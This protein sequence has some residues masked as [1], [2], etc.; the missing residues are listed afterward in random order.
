MQHAV[1]NAPSTLLVVIGHPTLEW[2]RLIAIFLAGHKLDIQTHVNALSLVVPVFLKTTPLVTWLVIPE[3]TISGHTMHEPEQT[4]TNVQE[5]ARRHPHLP[6]P[7]RR[8]NTYDGTTPRT[9]TGPQ[10]GDPAEV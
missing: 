8:N 10:T 9:R 7:L 4:A 6:R 5:T 1:L 2:F 3:V